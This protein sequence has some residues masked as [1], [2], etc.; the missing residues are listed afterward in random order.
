MRTPATA[1]SHPCGLVSKNQTRVPTTTR[2][3]VPADVGNPKKGD[4]QHAAEKL[5]IL[6]IQHVRR[7]GEHLESEKLVVACAR[8]RTA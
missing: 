6:E 4:V 1:Y 2:R 5:R 3:G 7:A 8:P